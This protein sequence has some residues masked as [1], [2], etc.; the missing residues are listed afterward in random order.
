MIATDMHVVLFIT[1][2]TWGL[3]SNYLIVLFISFISVYLYEK[4]MVR[5]INSVYLYFQK[6]FIV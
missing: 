5:M 2:V 4:L 1:I 6:T 3:V